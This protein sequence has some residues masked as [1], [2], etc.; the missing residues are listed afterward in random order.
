VLAGTIATLD[1]NA[2]RASS[3]ITPEMLAADVAELLAAEG[4]PFR[5]AHEAMGQLVQQAE[6]EGRDLSC[7]VGEKAGSVDP[8]LA[9]IR[10]EWWDVAAALERRSVAGGSSPAAVRDQLE[11]AR[12]R[13]DG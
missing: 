8:T 6:A 13:L 5:S 4:V 11:E 1:F 2:D 9:S 12:T 7:F 3:S 10:P